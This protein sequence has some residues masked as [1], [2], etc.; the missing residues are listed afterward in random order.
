MKDYLKLAYQT[1]DFLIEN[2]AHSTNNKK[3]FRYAKNLVV[4][5]IEI[6]GYFDFDIFVEWL[7]EILP[8]TWSNYKVPLKYMVYSM[9]DFILND[10]YTTT[11]FIFFD[12]DKISKLISTYHLDLI[13]RFVQSQNY[14]DSY[15]KTS[16]K[17]IAI[18]LYELEFQNK[19]INNLDYYDIIAFKN[20]YEIYYAHIVYIQMLNTIRLFIYFCLEEMVISNQNYYRVLSCGRLRYL[21]LITS[22]IFQIKTRNE[23]TVHIDVNNT[24]HFEEFINLH[25]DY[26]CSEQEVLSIKGRLE[27]L[28][29]FLDFLDGHLNSSIIEYWI[30]N[31]VKKSTTGWIEYRK[32]ALRY[33]DYVKKGRIDLSHIYKKRIFLI[34]KLPEWSKYWFNLYID[35]R[36]RLGFKKRT[37]DMDKA[38]IISFLLFMD[39]KHV[40]DYEEISPQLVVEYHNNDF[41]S[42]AES[43]NAYQ[44]KIRLFIRFI[45]DE[46]NMNLNF[47]CH[48]LSPVKTHSKI[49]TVLNDEIIETIYHHKDDFIS[50]I[51]LRHYAIFM[52]G[53]RMG[54]RR[55]DII[56]LTFSDISLNDRVLHLY[57]IKSSTDMDMPIPVVVANAIYRYVS[58]GRPQTSSEYIFVS[59]SH[60]YGKL[61]PSACS[62]VLDRIFRKLNITGDTGFHITRRTYATHILRE[63]H[64]IF[65]TAIAL[66]HTDNSNVHK[67]ISLDEI[68]MIKCCLDLTLIPLKG[69]LYELLSF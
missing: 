33:L 51:E 44:S 19:I 8:S 66:G 20:K 11:E 64:S 6:L 63:K 18:F 41:H 23:D 32:T 22:H 61:N 45:C 2:V 69:E 50:P 62:D 56:N 38:A 54:L 59:H 5:K 21:E 37:L 36:K 1:Y 49:V 15:K 27:C 12:C 58:Y 7:K 67:Y 9:N 17:R 57:Q 53:I 65:D 60:P 48:L 28:F 52:L 40:K 10:A 29:I 14:S 55:V 42:T 13:N 26:K 4:K 35:Y 31:I 16:E 34:D 39:K 46:S 24:T 47:I 3:S 30:D 25:I 68:Q 43:K